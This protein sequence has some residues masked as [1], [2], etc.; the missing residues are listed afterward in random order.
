V[1]IFDLTLIG[2][3]FGETSTDANWDPAADLSV[4]DTIDIFDLVMVGSNFDNAY[5]GAT[6]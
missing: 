4:D 3:H 2:T 1:N 5:E 6:C